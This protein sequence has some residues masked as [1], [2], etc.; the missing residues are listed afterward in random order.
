MNKK[1]ITIGLVVIAIV[2]V[3]AFKHVAKADIYGSSLVTWWTLDFSR[4]ST[5]ASGVLDSSGGGLDGTQFNTPT[6]IATPVQQGLTFNGT[7]QYLNRDAGPIPLSGVPLTMCYWAKGNMVLSMLATNPITVDNW[8]GW[9]ITTAAVTTNEN[10]FAS[11]VNNS[12]YNSAVWQ[13]LCAVHATNSSHIFYVNGIPSAT[14]TTL[15]TPL[16]LVGTFRVTVGATYHGSALDNFQAGSADDIRV[17]NRALSTAEIV[18]M[19]NNG[20]PFFNNNF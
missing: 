8:T 6:Q 18:E 14:D 19:Y 12:N 20:L 13:H 17:Y 3:V 11:I 16:P 10:S 4:Y 2:S 9:Y 7:T 15:V 1:L 5:G